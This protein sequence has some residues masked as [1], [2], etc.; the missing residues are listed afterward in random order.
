MRAAF[1]RSQ[2]NEKISVVLKRGDVRIVREEQWVC[3][4]YRSDGVHLR[5][6]MR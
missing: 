6:L 1:H 4:L 3:E 2:M 5:H